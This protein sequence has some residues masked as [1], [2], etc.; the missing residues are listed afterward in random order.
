LPVIGLY[1]IN[2][3]TKRGNNHV[4]QALLPESRMNVSLYQAAAA[5]KANSSWLDVITENMASS[6]VPGFRKQSLTTEAVQAGLMPAGSTSGSAPERFSLPKT[7]TSVCF[8][9]GELDYTGDDKNAAI[10]GSGFFQVQLANGMTAVTRDGEFR[11]GSKGQLETKEGYAV[12][13]S[14]GPIQ[15]DP[16]NPA[17]LAI[18][19]TGDVRQGEAIKGK[20]SL[21]DYENPELLTQTNGVYFL[22]TNP[23]LQTKPA[24]GTIKNGFV[25]S[26]NATALN[27]MA[28]MMTAMRTF[29]ANQHVIQ[30]QD[31]R[32]S[33]VISELGNPT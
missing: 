11:V 14:S 25:E 29:E 21:T 1:D 18:S 31:D 9:N 8:K 10:D 2:S 6:S 26:S 12:V 16:Q 5:L 3:R 15:L 20:L 22:A 28:N 32:M 30:I 4:A 23:A 19:A 13:G 33:K 24:D 27:E 17:P 7:S